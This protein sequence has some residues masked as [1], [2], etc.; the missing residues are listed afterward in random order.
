M[1]FGKIGDDYYLKFMLAT[2]LDFGKIGFGIQVPLNLKLTN[3]VELRKED[4]DEVSDYGKI[5]RYF[6]YGQKR[7][8]LYVRVGELAA[9]SIGHGTILHNFYNNVDVNHYRLGVQYDMTFKWGGWE[10]IMD[11]LLG[12]QV[13]GARVFLKPL[14]WFAPNSYFSRL[15][16]GFSLIGDVNAPNVLATT[17]TGT[18]VVT[19]EKTTQS[20]NAATGVVGFDI[21]FPIIESKFY[22]LIP[23]SD[24]NLMLGGGPGQHFGVIQNFKFHK[25]FRFDMRLEFRA[26]SNNYLPTYFDSTYMVTRDQYPVGGTSTKYAFTTRPA[27]RTPTQD[28][29]GAGFYGEGLFNIF[30]LVLVTFIFEDASGD[31]NAAFTASAKVP[32]LKA[33]Q[34]GAYFTKRNFDQPGD[35]LF[36]FKNALLVAEARVKMYGPLFFGALFTRQWE[37]AASGKYEPSDS[38][39]VGVQAA[40]NF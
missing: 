4:W 21:E 10:T 16:F 30:N 22:D 20:T 26:L 15:T 33:F 17:G 38:F 9:A 29:S 7:E 31:G 25:N 32:A 5:I 27:S 35:S 24:T 40:F 28:I 6:R 18:P 39:N 8:T 1:G 12:P 23:Y 13:F 34:V 36:S 19:A 2:E 3:G 37:L 11:N 14:A